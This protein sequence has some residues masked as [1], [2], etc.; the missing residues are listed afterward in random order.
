MRLFI[1]Q[2]M[3]QM[4]KVNKIPILIVVLLIGVNFSCSLDEELQSTLNKEQGTE[5]LTGSADIDA[6]L[7][8]AYEAM[9]L[10]YQDQSRYWA[11]TEHTTDEAMGPTRGGDW[12]DN[13][14]WRVLHDHTW[15]ADHAFLGD[16][17]NDLLN[18]VFRTTDLLNYEP[19]AQQEA[20]ALMLRAYVMFSVADGWGQVPFREPGGNLLDAPNV[21]SGSDAVDKV[22]AD[23]ERVMSDLPDGPAYRANKDAAKVL[24]MKAYLNRG[25]FANRQSPTFDVADMNTVISLADEIIQSGKYS[26]SDNMYDNFAPNNDVISTENIFTNQNRPGIPGP[27]NSVRARWFCTLHYNQNPSGWNGFT[28][29][30]DFYDKFDPNDQGLKLTIQV[31]QMYLDSK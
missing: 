25:V 24:L 26:I 13:G 1:N 2:T 18:I 30:A 11:A 3:S 29:I 28:T 7:Q 10:P 27:G 15:D 21:L 9:R 17:F 5:F 4:K 6:L 14:V 23:V 22:I 31:T 12:D 16:T 19:T 20:E 8:S